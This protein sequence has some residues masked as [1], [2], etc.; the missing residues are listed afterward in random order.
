MSSV[1]S[2]V[3]EYINVRVCVCVSGSVHVRMC[4][5]GSVCPWRCGCVFV[6]VHVS[7]LFMVWVAVCI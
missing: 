4:V 7:V 2:Y 3:H 5:I 1:W 6:R